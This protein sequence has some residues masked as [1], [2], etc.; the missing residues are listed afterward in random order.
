MQ[1]CAGTA[2]TGCETVQ[3]DKVQRKNP[4]AT[5]DMTFIDISNFSYH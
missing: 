1:S 4:K 2:A 3:T 5:P